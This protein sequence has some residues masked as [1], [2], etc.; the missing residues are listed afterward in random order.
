M[1]EAPLGEIY[2]RIAWFGWNGTEKPRNDRAPIR[3]Y[4]LALSKK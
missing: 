4:V 3:M 1:R 2:L